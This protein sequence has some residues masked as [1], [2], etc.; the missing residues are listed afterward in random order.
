MIAISKSPLWWGEG[1]LE[2]K[3][4]T[5]FFWQLASALISTISSLSTQ[6]KSP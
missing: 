2:I 1:L 5:P 4:M 3:W 6:G